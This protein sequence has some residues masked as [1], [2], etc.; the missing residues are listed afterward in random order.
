[1]IV[2]ILSKEM[3]EEK[4]FEIPSVKRI[5]HQKSTRGEFFTVEWEMIPKLK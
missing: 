5:I 2:H 4:M 3:E 1:M